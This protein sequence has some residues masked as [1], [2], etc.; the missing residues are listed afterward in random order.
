M[1][2]AATLLLILGY[3]LAL[4]IM[5]RWTVTVGWRRTMAVRGAQVGLLIAGAGW[6]ARGRAVI[7]VAHLL[8]GL[9]LPFWIPLLDRLVPDRR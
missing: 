2:P 8:A 5:V 1:N 4:P 3:S 9:A 7:G 6:L